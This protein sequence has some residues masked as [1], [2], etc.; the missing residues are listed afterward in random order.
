LNQTHGHIARTKNVMRL[1]T[2]VVTVA[3]LWWLIADGQP[4]SWII[5][6]PAILYASWAF[7]RLKPQPGIY[8]S[9]T[10][11]LRFIPFFLIESLRGG[12]DVASRTLQP[13][14][15]INPGFYRHQMKLED[16]VKRVF[17][18]NCVNLLPGTLT[19]DIHE[20]WIEIHLLSEDI[21]PEAGLLRLEEAVGRIFQ[22]RGND[23]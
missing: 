18:I 10:G 14:L 6:I 19:A 5:G 20:E 7:V 2:I 15:N 3:A 16:N 8:V 12:I 13:R 9:L 1:L 11:L 4:S 22:T 23:Q 17:F 21:N